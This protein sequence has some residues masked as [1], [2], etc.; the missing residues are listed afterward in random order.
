MTITMRHTA[1][2]I[3]MRKKSESKTLAINE[4][5]TLLGLKD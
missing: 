5:P 4:L 1:A 3:T 2:T